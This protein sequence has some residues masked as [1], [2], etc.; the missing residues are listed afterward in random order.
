MSRFRN[1]LIFSAIFVKTVVLEGSSSVEFGL[2]ELWRNYA[3][4]H[5]SLAVRLHFVLPCSDHSQSLQ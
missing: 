3:T 1:L 4:L 2:E 5:A